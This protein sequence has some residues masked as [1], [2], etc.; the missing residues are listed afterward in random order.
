MR[1]RFKELEKNEY[2]FGRLP[3]HGFKGWLSTSFQD[4]RLQEV[5]KQDTQLGKVL[6]SFLYQHAAPKAVWPKSPQ[7][8]IELPIIPDVNSL[9]G[10]TI[11]GAHFNPVSV[12]PSGGF[13]RSGVYDLIKEH[14]G[15]FLE[16][17]HNSFVTKVLVKD[18]DGAKPIAYGVEVKEGTSLY[19]ASTGDQHFVG[20]KK[21]YFARKEVI[22]AGGAFNTPQILKLSGIGPK[23]EL[24][25]FKIDVK[26]DVPGVGENLRDKLEV[27]VN[28]DMAED[29]LVTKLGCKFNGAETDVCYEAWKDGEPSAYSLNGVL[30]SAQKKSHPDLPYP[31]VYLQIGANYFTGYKE[32]WVQTVFAEPNVLSLIVNTNS[33]VSGTVTLRSSDPFAEAV[34]DFGGY[35]DEDLMKVV[36]QIKEFRELMSDFLAADEALD[37]TVPGLDV[38]TDEEL[39]AYARA[40][41][42]GH[43]ACCSAKMGA[44]D[45]EMAV[46]N[47]KFQVR[48]VDNLRVVDNSVFPDMPGFY[49]MVSL[50]MTA[51]KAAEDIMG[52]DIAVD[53]EAMGCK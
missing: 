30:G 19:E 7:G 34:I 18:G 40:A 10:N 6:L 33:R 38:H 27:T 21:T 32:G 53:L 52:A 20:D 3:G 1:K 12:S 16:V 39:L 11:E 31:D 14:E 26:A 22:I 35:A 13:I 4:P 23:A 36:H 49:P 24:E 5:L 29:W 37:E 15:E 45:D 50:Y 46:L 9:F 47:G 48:G 28:Y 43:H 17:Q 44:D 42:W 41:G 51:E 25:K 2:G 8:E